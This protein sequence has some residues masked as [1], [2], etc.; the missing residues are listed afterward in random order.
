MYCHTSSSVHSAQAG[1]PT[2]AWF[3]TLMQRVLEN[4]T[5]CFLVRITLRL[6]R[7]GSLPQLL[8][9]QASTTS[10]PKTQAQ[11]RKKNKK[12]SNRTR[13]KAAWCFSLPEG[14][15]RSH[16]PNRSGKHDVV[17]D[18]CEMRTALPPAARHECVWMGGWALFRQRED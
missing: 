16:I 4:A 6:P 14:S 1:K 8:Q 12:S 3:Q 17:L 9:I 13:G 5:A 18:A 2:F 10:K 11:E 15:T 7:E